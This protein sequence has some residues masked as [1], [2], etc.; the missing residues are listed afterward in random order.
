MFLNI[1][2]WVI[3]AIASAMISEKKGYNQVLWFIL[4]I[5]FGI[6]A[7]AV[8]IFLPTKNESKNKEI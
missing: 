8:V 5:V 3:F 7:L 6:F 4:G 1:V 2:I